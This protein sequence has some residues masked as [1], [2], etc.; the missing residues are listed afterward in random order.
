MS[1][2]IVTSEANANPATVWIDSR[3]EL[4]FAKLHGQRVKWW[5]ATVSHNLHIKLTTIRTTRPHFVLLK[6]EPTTPRP[7]KI[8]MKTPNTTIRTGT[9]VNF[10]ES[11]GEITTSVP[12]PTSA[13]APATRIA[14][15]QSCRHRKRTI[16]HSW[17]MPKCQ[18]VKCLRPR[19]FALHWNVRCCGVI[20]DSCAQYVNRPPL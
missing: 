1:N 12:S 6:I 16:F 13:H 5:N 8:M 11:A 7:L 17:T 9:P 3:K 4:C 14:K 15:P 2:E 10:S 18:T 19:Y 20:S